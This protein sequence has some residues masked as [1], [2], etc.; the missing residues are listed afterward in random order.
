M[1]RGKEVDLSY[2][3]RE[4]REGLPQ[5][6]LYNAEKLSPSQGLSK[7]WGSHLLLRN[8]HGEK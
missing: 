4:K 3:K 7:L 5:F 6:T 8:I 1:P 2:T